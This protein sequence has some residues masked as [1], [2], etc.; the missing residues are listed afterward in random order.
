MEW[1]IYYSCRPFIM[2]STIAPVRPWILL[3]EVHSY[4]LLLLKLQLL[5]KRWHPTKVGV[6]KELK[7][8]REVEV[9]TSSR[10]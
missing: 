5:W 4:H 7:P 8:S 10:R 6:K 1:R 3:L 9:C 2:G